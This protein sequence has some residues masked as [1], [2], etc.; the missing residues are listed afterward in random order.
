MTQSNTTLSAYLHWTKKSHVPHLRV[1]QPFYHSDSF[2]ERMRR[3]G[4]PARWDQANCEWDYPLTPA[5]V[6]QL[7]KVCK[8]FKLDIVWSEDLQD[9]AEKQTSLDE[10]EEKVRL[11]IE[12]V[13]RDK[14][15]LPAYVTN[16][17][18]GEKPPMRHQQLVYHWAMRT[19]GL[20]VA[21]EPGLGKTR[22]ATDAAGGWYRESV[23]R[24]MTNYNDDGSPR[25]YPEVSTYTGKYDKR[26]NPKKKFEQYEHWGV[27]GGI[28]VICPSGVVRTW[29]REMGQWQGMTSVEI[30]GGKKRKLEKSGMVAHAHIVNYESLH[31]V[32]HNDYD[33]IIVDESHRCANNTNQTQNVLELGLKAR[34]RILLSGSPV[35]NSLESVFYQM[36]IVDGGRSLGANHR[37]FMDEFFNSEQVGPGKP[38][39]TPRP[40]A[41][42]TVSS[43]MSRAAYFLKKEECLDLPPK[44]HTPVYMDM[45]PDQQRYYDALKQ[46]ALAYIQDSTVT[47]EQ[48]SAKMMKLLQVCQGI[49]KDDEGR[50]REFN[51]IKRQNL[52][53]DLQNELVGRKVIVWCRFS[54]EI[55]VLIRQLQE[56]NIWALRYDGQVKSKEM[57]NRIIQAWN[58]D[59]RY[60]VFVG[61]ISMG[62]G[63]ELV[64]QNCD[65]PCFDT[66][67][68][69]LDYRYVSWVQSQDRTHRIIQKHPCNYK[70]LLTPNG[71]DNQ[72]YKSLLVKE[73]TASSV[74]KTGKDFFMSLLTDDSPDLASVA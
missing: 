59:P 5:S 62:E 45:L 72:V 44:L 21:H 47:V 55:D 8:E 35:S 57:R 61:Q 51:D 70:Y 2:A 69:G 7:R 40:G 37:M 64:A 24:P 18:G 15:E 27:Q 32:M 1:R 65:V 67:Y 42:E 43:Q 56:R 50:W 39:Y 10:Y 31:T 63:I 9:F 11:A 22:A 58:E 26:G 19:S 20:L 25:F 12:K 54:H 29:S 33:A 3:V 17:F 41:I 38:K 66:Y 34:R 71:V 52:M 30:T 36:L 14:S 49:I 53:A 60:T 13:M 23:I 68:L 48:A 46:D 73:R 4:S 28:L 74:H 16:D 6:S